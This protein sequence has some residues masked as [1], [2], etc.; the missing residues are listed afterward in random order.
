MEASCT[1]AVGE[2]QGETAEERVE[3]L[4]SRKGFPGKREMTENEKWERVYTILFPD[5][6]SVPSPCKLFFSF[7]FSFF[8]LS[9]G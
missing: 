6:P 3:A 5:D 1:L 9:S 4:R 7:S 8:L 2:S